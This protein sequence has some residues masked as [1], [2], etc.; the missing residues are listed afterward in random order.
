MYIENANTD[1]ISPARFLSFS[2]KREVDLFY[3]F[4]AFPDYYI[5]IPFARE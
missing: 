1:V 3:G 4:A 2:R 5:P